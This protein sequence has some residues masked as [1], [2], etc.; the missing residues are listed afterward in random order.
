MPPASIPPKPR[1]DLF[2][3]GNVTE[4][5]L[6]A[7]LLENVDADIGA[8]AKLHNEPAAND[9]ASFKTE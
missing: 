8:M 3:M 4:L 1:A 2:G 6:R 5:D 7:N 9:R